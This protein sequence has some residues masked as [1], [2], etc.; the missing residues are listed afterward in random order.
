VRR[1][2]AGSAIGRFTTSTGMTGVGVRAHGEDEFWG[3]ADRVVVSAGVTLEVA[4]QPIT[5]GL[6]LTQPWPDDRTLRPS[7]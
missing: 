6:E 5:D 4:D 3:A 2:P 1:R 7:A